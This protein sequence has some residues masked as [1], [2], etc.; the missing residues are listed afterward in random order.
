MYCITAMNYSSLLPGWNIDTPPITSPLQSHHPSNNTNRR[1]ND[2]AFTA[3]VHRQ[4]HTNGASSQ[5]QGPQQ[6]LQQRRDSITVITSTNKR[7]LCSAASR[8]G[9]MFDGR[10]Y[11]ISVCRCVCVCVCALSHETMMIRQHNH[12]DSCV[13]HNTVI[14]TYVLQ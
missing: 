8:L 14:M 3:I 2:H 7:R 5:S 1:V 6:Q 12:Y 11:W 4:S 13:R 10:Q 9:L